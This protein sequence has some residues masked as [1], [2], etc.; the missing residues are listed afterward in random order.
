MNEF[1]LQRVEEATMASSQE[2]PVRLME[3]GG[4]ERGELG[5][6]NLGCVLAFRDP[7]EHQTGGVKETGIA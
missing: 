3:A 2:L 7:R 5:G 4:A 1:D 6:V